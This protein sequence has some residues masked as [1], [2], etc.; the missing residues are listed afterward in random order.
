MSDDR[1]I[2]D[3]VLAETSR[4]RKTP[5]TV[6]AIDWGRKLK[7]AAALLADPNCTERRYLQAIRDLGL[8]EGDSE[9][10]KCL[11]LWRDNH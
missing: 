1:D 5:K 9:F 11:R 10:E 3:V 7:K 8:Q 2:Q 4:G 6:N